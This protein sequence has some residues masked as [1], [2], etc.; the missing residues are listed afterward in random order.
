MH[1]GY[2]FTL[3][4]CGSASAASPATAVLDAMLAVLPP[5]KR[6]AYLGEVVA[7]EALATQRDE[8]I[9]ACIADV[10]DAELLLLVTPTHGG[11]PPQRFSRLLSAISHRY[12]TD[13]LS[14]KIV[15][16]VTIGEA[17]STP[18]LTVPSGVHLLTQLHLSSDSPAAD[19]AVALACDAYATA[20]RYVRTALP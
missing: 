19:Q 11:V 15:V 6:A 13:D 8:L 18:A 1:D 20:R 3:G 17:E 16:V 5:V 4:I 12:G 10:T 14:E 9:A 2:I 7:L